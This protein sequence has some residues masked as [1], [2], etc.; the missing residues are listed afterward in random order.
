MEWLKHPIGKWPLLFRNLHLEK[1]TLKYLMIHFREKWSKQLQYSNWGWCVTQ[2]WA[3][4]DLQAE[5]FP[6]DFFG[7]SCQLQQLKQ[8]KCNDLREPTHI[9]WKKT[10]YPSRRTTELKHNVRNAALFLKHPRNRFIH[11]HPS[12]LIHQ[13]REELLSTMF[14]NFWSKAWVSWRSCRTW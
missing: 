9:L 11:M 7:S 10:Q 3:N 2:E 8:G 13:V 12:I 5:T 6:M 4:N 1:L 14:Q